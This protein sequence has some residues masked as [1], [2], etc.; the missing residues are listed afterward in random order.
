MQ[1]IMSVLAVVFSVT[2]IVY[3][4]T[5][6]VR[7][8]SGESPIAD[9]Q[10][11]ALPRAPSENCVSAP[12]LPEVKRDNAA[13]RVVDI[14]SVEALHQAMTDLRANTILLLS[15]GRYDL[16]KTLSVEV[17]NVTIRGDSTRCDAVALVGKGMDNVAGDKLIPHGVW[18]NARNLKV[19]NLSIRDVYRHAI[20]IDGN[21]TSP[22]LYNLALIDTGEQFVKVN[23]LGYGEGVDKGRVEY[24]LIRYSDGP[25][26]TDH[27]SGTGYTNGIDIHAGNGWTIANNMFVD[28]HVPDDSDH[29]WN[30]AILSWN[31][32]SNTIVEHN[33]FHNVDRAIAFGLSDR[34]ADHRGG[35]IRHNM[36]ALDADLFS[37]RR[38]ETADAPILVWSSPDTQIENNSIV[39]R[40][41]A[42]NAIELRF[43]S[44]GAWIARNIIDAAINDRDNSIVTVRD[45][46]TIDTLTYFVDPS[47][48]DLR[49]VDHAPSKYSGLGAA[50]TPE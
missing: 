37:A 38:R 6:L 48:A 46:L 34:D 12:P 40:G 20:A 21:A 30:P 41:N 7:L 19:Q 31:G 11:A 24:S 39:T 1:K 35:I 8:D 42:R 50:D 26:K 36:I 32:A 10:A 4:A 28:I 9:V 49:L 45:N 27:G 47:I 5:A 16:Q 13:V 33:R 23:P 3:V 18:T 22:E 44:D 17:D 43:K 25:A 29:L 15:P 14:D 2:A